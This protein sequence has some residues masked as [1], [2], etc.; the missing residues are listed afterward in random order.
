MRTSNATRVASIEH[1]HTAATTSHAHAAAEVRGRGHRTQENQSSPACNGMIRTNRNRNNGGGT[2]A[3]NLGSGSDIITGGRRRRRSCRSV[4]RHK[5]DE[6]PQFRVRRENKGRHERF[7]GAG[8]I[9]RVLRAPDTYLYNVCAKG[10]KVPGVCQRA[11]ERNETGT[12]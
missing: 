3:Y 4:T 8:I 11:H 9:S 6:E 12:P 2:V 10:E 1:R 7:L 5:L